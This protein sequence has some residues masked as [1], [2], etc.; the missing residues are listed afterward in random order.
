MKKYIVTIITVSVLFAQNTD[1]ETQ[2][3]Y[4]TIYLQQGFFGQRY[5]K[6]GESFPLK[7]IRKEMD[8]Y[9]ESSQLYGKS[10]FM[11]MVGIGAF[12][13]GPVASSVLVET[14]ESSFLS[15]YIGSLFLGIVASYEAY[16]KLHEAIW[17]YNRESLKTNVGSEGD[18]QQDGDWQW[19]KIDP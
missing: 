3:Y 13:L 2:Y 16:N 5:V 15:V 14:D 8:L 12:V 11:S 17:V 1:F 19:R 6:G 4:E 9:P 7:S 18:I 10:F